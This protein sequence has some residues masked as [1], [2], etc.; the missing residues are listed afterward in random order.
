MYISLRISVYFCKFQFVLQV[1]TIRTVVFTEYLLYLHLYF[2]TSLHLNLSQSLTY[3]LTYTLTLNLLIIR[4]E[5]T[6]S[7]C[8][9][10][11]KSI[12]LLELVCSLSLH[13]NLLQSLT[14]T[15]TLTHLPLIRLEIH[16]LIV[17]HFAFRDASLVL[18]ELVC[19]DYDSLESSLTHYNRLFI[20]NYP[21]PPHQP[22]LIIPLPS[23]LSV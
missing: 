15:L 11:W 1:C 14:Y 3:S 18:L 5:M 19:M 20:I 22:P 23:S 4:L 17:N 13:L 6:L 2:T 12:V 7:D 16:S 21:S 10:L 8:E 9:P